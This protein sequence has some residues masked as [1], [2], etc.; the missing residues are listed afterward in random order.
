MNAHRIH[1]RAL[2]QRTGRQIEDDRQGLLAII[3]TG[4][5]RKRAD[6]VPVVFR[7][8]V[9]PIDDRHPG[10]TPHFGE[11]RVIEQANLA[12]VDLQS[13][14]TRQSQND[15]SCQLFLNFKIGQRQ[16]LEGQV[17]LVRWRLLKVHKQHLAVFDRLAHGRQ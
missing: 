9:H 1:H 14:I 13:C 15:K 12:T 8:L 7:P 11:G 10:L 5:K 16:P 17:G 6:D 3:L 2:G 4:S